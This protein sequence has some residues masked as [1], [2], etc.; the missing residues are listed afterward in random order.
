MGLGPPDLNLEARRS[1]ENVPPA[2]VPSQVELGNRRLIQVRLPEH[3]EEPK[4]EAH[5]QG[6][7]KGLK[8]EVMVQRQ[9]SSGGRM[10]RRSKGGI[11]MEMSAGVRP[12]SLWRVLILNT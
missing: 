6:R 10:G 2:S 11:H 3:S 9:W 7:T 4:V 1:H 12:N 5:P 8:L